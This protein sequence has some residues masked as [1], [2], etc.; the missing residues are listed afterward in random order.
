MAFSEL[1]QARVNKLLSE[2]LERRRPPPHIRS[3]LD[4]G[5]RIYGQSIELF[6]VRP[7]WRGKPGQKVEHAIAK[8]TYI[9]SHE[10]WRIYWQRADMKWHRYEPHPSA[11]SVQHLAASTCKCNSLSEGFH[12]FS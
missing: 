1:E 10:L 9:K 4:L 6:E 7:A 8:A 12:L 5:Y 3:Q 2:W 11:S